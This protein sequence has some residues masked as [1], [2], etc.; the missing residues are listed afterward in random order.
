MKP[1]TNVKIHK[2]SLVKNFFLVTILS[3][4]VSLIANALTKESGLIITLIPGIV[5]VLLVA[6]FYIKEYF[7]CSSYDT[8]V[9]TILSVDNEKRVIPIDR[10]EFSENFHRAVLS[11][12]SENKAYKSLWDD[13]FAHRVG[14]GEKGKKF[15]EEFL[16]YLFIDWISLKLNSYFVDVDDGLTEIIVREN[17][18][19]VLIKNRVIDLITKPFEEREKFQEK[20]GHED[21]IEGKVV[22]MD[23]D[24][25]VI[26]DM[27]EIELP[28]K[29]KVFRDKQ[30]LLITN[31]NFN[32][33]FESDFQGFS[34]VLPRYFE[35]FYMNRSLDT[36]HSY[37]I[38]VKL[39]I[40]LK[41]F[42][43]VS[44][45]DWKYLGWLDQIEEEFVK[46]FSFDEFVEKIGFEQAL[47]NHI[48][49]MNALE[50]KEGGEEEGDDRR[51]DDFRIVK[52][53]DE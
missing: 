28:R 35:D 43:L 34:G 1:I 47:T 8:S 24:D 14:E 2:K 44:F 26:Y 27:L 20:I 52:V 49:F 51:Y 13:A 36:V 12:L 42:F 30:S 25:G 53:E 40:K 6:F 45:R 41:P 10:F 50:E 15:V 23:G 18:P 4:G 19:D 37:M 46:Y 16:E 7:G 29:S 48:L 17:I 3:T 39:S 5:C 9:T 21:H 11:V 31:R 22:Y 32:I 38:K 33:R